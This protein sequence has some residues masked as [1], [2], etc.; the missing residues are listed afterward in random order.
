MD[1]NPKQ[2]QKALFQHFR[3]FLGA[4]PKEKIFALGNFPIN[5]LSCEDKIML[6]Q[7]FSLEEIE[8]ALKSTE[9]SK[10]PGPD[11]LNAR[12]LKSLWPIL[13]DDILKFFK[14][15]GEKNFIAKGFNASFI[16]LIAKKE[17]PKSPGDYRPISLMNAVMKLITKTLTLWIKKVMNT[18]ISDA[19]SA[20]IK[21][22]QISDCILLASEVYHCLKLRKNKGVIF[23]VDF[24]KAFDCINW[25]FLFKVMEK[26]NFDM[27]WINWIK[28]MFSTSTISM[29]V[30][31]VPT[32]EFSLKRGLR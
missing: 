5:L 24:E 28:T 25:D 14:E 16:A 29:L 30:N 21:G 9:S 1:N 2:Y 32:N 22:R 11:G 17:V 19:Q 26:M 3:N 7:D 6:V 12:V 23:K 27:K 4:D 13:K 15:F 31:G 20:F 8:A 10:A 18:L